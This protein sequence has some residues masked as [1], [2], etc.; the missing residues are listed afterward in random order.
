MNRFKRNPDLPALRQQYETA[1]KN[2]VKMSAAGVKIGLGTD[3]GSADTYPGYFEL[4]ELELM[5]AAGMKPA[6][7]IKA[8]TSAS[9]DVLGLKDMGALAVGKDADFIIFSSN[10]LEKMTNV[11][12]IA[13]IYMKGAELD[14]RKFLDNINNEV[15]KVTAAD[16][17]AD[18]QAQVDAARVA[19]DA[20]LEQFGKFPLGPS[21]N[22]RS[23]PVPTPK[24]SKAD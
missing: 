10:P 15:P 2:L 14:R 13:S 20:K 21:A 1:E 16:I 5:A 4:R 19:A 18:A 7:V 9:A 8:A 3:S 17:K 6:E 22:V 11:K 23:M 12:D 24:Y